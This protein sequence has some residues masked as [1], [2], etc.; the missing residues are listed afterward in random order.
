[1]FQIRVNGSTGYLAMA[2]NLYWDA[3]G[4]GLQV[5]RLGLGSTLGALLHAAYSR[6]L[7]FLLHTEPCLQSCQA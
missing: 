2:G 3:K 4:A 7:A 6:A 1:M 5:R